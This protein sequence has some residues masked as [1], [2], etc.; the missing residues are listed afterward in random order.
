MVIAGWVVWSIT[1]MLFLNNFKWQVYARSQ[2]TESAGRP[3]EKTIGALWK[4]KEKRLS[5]IGHGL[6]AGLVV[7]G[8][9]SSFPKLWLILFVPIVFI[10]GNWV[11]KRSLLKSAINYLSQ[12]D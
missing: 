8:F 5:F 6:L 3:E 4:S 9:C 1:L 10:I 11:E 12:N 2:S 7:F